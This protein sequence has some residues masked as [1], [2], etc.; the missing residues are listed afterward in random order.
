MDKRG[1]SRR[2]ILVG[3]LLAVL[4]TAIAV[5]NA[6]A[7]AA[8]AAALLEFDAELERLRKGG[9]REHETYQRAP[10]AP[11]VIGCA[12]TGCVEFGRWRRRSGRFAFRR[13]P[14]RGSFVPQGFR[15]SQ[16]PQAHERQTDSESADRNDRGEHAR[17]DDRVTG[18]LSHQVRRRDHADQP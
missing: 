16:T 8:T 14:A 9:P 18:I 7:P 2:E 4:P 13:S 5:A 11:A 15:C 17:G 6:P 12:A 3:S 10:R 1:T